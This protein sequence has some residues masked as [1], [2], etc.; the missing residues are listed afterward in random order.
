MII[1]TM[2]AFFAAIVSFNVQAKTAWVA[3]SGDNTDTTFVKPTAIAPDGQFVDVEVLRDHAETI[4]MGN[5][6]R[7]GSPLYPHRSVTLTYRV[8]CTTN[9]L[10]VAEWQMHGAN[11]GQGDTV[12]KQQNRDGLAFLPA[13]NEEMR[14]VLNAA[15]ATT[16]VSR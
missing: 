11:L 8:D 7:N 16:T 6:S 2:I 10:A 9:T 3:L 5:D 4:T 14:A 15:C 1:R 12:W 13:V